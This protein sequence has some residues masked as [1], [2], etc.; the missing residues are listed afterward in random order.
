MVDFRVRGAG[1]AQ[2][3]RVSTV[4]DVLDVRRVEVDEVEYSG[5]D[6]RIDVLSLYFRLHCC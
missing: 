1:Y 4:A 2:S 6:G 5:G 3:T